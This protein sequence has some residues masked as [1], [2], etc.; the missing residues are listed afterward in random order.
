MS[1]IKTFAHSAS[2]LSILINLLACLFLQ[3]EKYF[4]L[5]RPKEAPAVLRKPPTKAPRPHPAGSYKS[6]PVSGPPV[7]RNAKMFEDMLATQMSKGHAPGSVGHTAEFDK[8]N[9]GDVKALAR[10][11]MKRASSVDSLDVCLPLN[12]LLCNNIFPI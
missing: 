8:E 2:V 10:E 12:N 3:G 5:K 9:R 4:V 11:H 1:F 6:R 7:M